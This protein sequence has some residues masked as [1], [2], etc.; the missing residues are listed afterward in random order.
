M[1]DG[2]RGK[3]RRLPILAKEGRIQ[4]AAVVRYCEVGAYGIAVTEGGILPSVVA[5]LDLRSF[6]F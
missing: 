1:H 3:R 2:N 4:E 5:Y 6:F